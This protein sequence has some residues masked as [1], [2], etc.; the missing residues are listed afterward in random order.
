VNTSCH[1]RVRGPLS[2]TSAIDRPVRRSAK[3][4]GSALPGVLW[5]LLP[6]CPLCLAAWITA[7]TGIALPAVVANSVRPSLAIACV[8]SAFLLLCRTLRRC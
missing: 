4:A 6:K 8:V 2:T 1:A 7:G 3:T 5:L